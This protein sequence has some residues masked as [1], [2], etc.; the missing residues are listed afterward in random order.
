M[1]T[2]TA[3]NSI[4]VAAG[5]TLTFCEGGIGQAILDGNIYTLGMSDV[6]LGPFASAETI[7]VLVTSGPINYYTTSAPAAGANM[8]PVFVDPLT[9]YTTPASGA[10]FVPATRDYL[11]LE[12]AISACRVVGGGTVLCD[13]ADY[14]LTQGGTNSTPVRSYSNIVIKGVPPRFITGNIPDSGSGLQRAGGTWFVGNGLFHGLAINDTDYVSSP[15]LAN[16]ATNLEAQ[17]AFTAAAAQGS[18]VL[19][20]G[21]D[22]CLDGIHVGGT[23]GAGSTYSRFRVTAINCQGWGAWFENNLHNDYEQI[24]ALANI[25]GQVRFRSSSSNAVLQTAN[26][27]VGELICTRPSGSMTSRGVVISCANGTIGGLAHSGILQS[28]AFSP[29]VVQVAATMTNGSPNVGVPNGSIFIPNVSWVAFTSTA[30]GFEVNRCYC[31]LSVVGN[32]VTL[33]LEPF[34]AA[35]NATDANAI[36]LQSN[37]MPLLE[38]TVDDATPANAPSLGTV[39][40]LDLEAGGTVKMVMV[41]S[42]TAQIIAPAIQPAGS[43]QDIVFRRAGPFWMV[44]ANANNTDIDTLS[45]YVAVIDSARG[46]SSVGALPVFLC[47]ASPQSRFLNLAGGVL[48]PSGATLQNK[49]PG[50]SDWTYPGVPIG[51]KTVSM[52]NT[53]LTINSGT[54]GGRAVFTGASAGAWT[55]IDPLGNAALFGFSQEIHNA[56]S[57]Y[58]TLNIQNAKV[59]NGQAGLTQLIVGPGQSFIGGVSATGGNNAWSGSVTMAPVQLLPNAANDAAAAALAP[60]VPVGGLYRNGSALMVRVA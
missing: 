34:G 5:N 22:N 12:V 14:D 11:G 57:Q 29:G 50:N 37:G 21:F 3:N 27:R 53:A 16:G 1:A 49:S 52:G 55:L 56:S 44:T 40:S 26:C 33:G 42:T 46:T 25:K 30:N 48:S 54:G 4:T 2:I 6:F 35:I 10:V 38:L 18:N 17:A 47:Y 32:V 9:G 36:T 23:F 58:L 28:N 60:S 59:F 24:T 19:D 45:P 31:V 8:T 13:S 20:I 15:Y 43:I 7:Q 41:K 51:Q 39:A